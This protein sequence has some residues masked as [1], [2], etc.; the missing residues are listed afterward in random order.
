MELTTIK[1][2]STKNLLNIFLCFLPFSFIA[3]NLAI[4]LNLLLIIILSSIFY[5]KDIIS[6]KFFLIDRL[7]IF[8]F[9]IYF[10]CR[11]F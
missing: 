6:S 3:G 5:G 7:I 9:F 10:C 4:N 8:F 2:F 1:V 11:A